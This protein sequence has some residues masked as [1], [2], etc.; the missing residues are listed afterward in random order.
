MR[1]LLN[2]FAAVV[3]HPSSPISMDENNN[4]EPFFFHQF[5]SLATCALCKAVL[6]VTYSKKKL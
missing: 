2:G 4:I 5:S 6:S 3:I 1:W